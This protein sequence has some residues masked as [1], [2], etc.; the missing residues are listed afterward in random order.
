MVRFSSLQ[1]LSSWFSGFGACLFS[2]FFRTLRFF[3]LFQRGKER[4]RAVLNSR[5]PECTKFFFLHHPKGLVTQKPCLSLGRYPPKYKYKPPASSKYSMDFKL[6]D[7]PSN[8]DTKFSLIR[9]KLRRIVREDLDY[10]KINLSG[11][12]EATIN[13]WLKQRYAVPIQF[14]KNDPTLLNVRYLCIRSGKNRTKFPKFDERV[15]YLAGVIFGDGHIK[16]HI[17]KKGYRCYRILIDKKKTTY[18][19]KY[20]PRLF[21]SVFGVSPRLSFKKRKSD[22]VRIAI[23]SKIISRIFTNLLGFSYGKKKPSMLK[24][25]YLWSKP[26]Q[27]HFIA[28][29]FDTDGGKSW[30]SYMFGN[31]SRPMILFVKKFLENNH[32]RTKLYRQVYP[33]SIYYHVFILPKYKNRFLGLIP[34]QNT[35]KF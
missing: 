3:F 20:L 32:I 15:A 27:K 6:K 30:N 7:L 28:G 17:R 34:L 16:N 21:K 1:I 13:D 24:Y 8:E 19:E 18:S 29:L 5:L 33:T 25:V 11:F 4:K 22:I 10:E 26:L 31:T 12:S 23:N 9:V 2:F 35:S 14:L